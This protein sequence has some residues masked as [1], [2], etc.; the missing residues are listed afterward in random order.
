MQSPLSWGER[1]ARYS[2]AKSFT[3]ERYIENILLTY[4]IAKNAP[5]KDLDAIYAQYNF[6]NF[7]DQIVSSGKYYLFHNKNDFL[8]EAKD[9]E[10]YDHL[11]PQSKRFIYPLGGH[12]GNFNF[13]INKMDLRSVLEIK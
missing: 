6:E 5:E 10:E 12:C 8:L 9:L 2:E 1:S 11:F 13:P 3:F 4:L 7:K